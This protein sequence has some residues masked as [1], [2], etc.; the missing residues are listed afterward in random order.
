MGTKNRSG[1]GTRQG[2]GNGKAR[3]FVFIENDEVL[4]CCPP[5]L[6]SNTF[7]LY[8]LALGVVGY[9]CTSSLEGWEEGYKQDNA[10]KSA[11]FHLWYLYCMSF[12]SLM[13]P[14]II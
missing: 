7:F 11:D 10:L 2:Y 12:F 5:F 1:P 9:C 3:V 8:S 4:S 13:A 14:F 6:Y